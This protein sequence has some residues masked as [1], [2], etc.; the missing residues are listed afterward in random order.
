MLLTS[1][2]DESDGIK[3][4]EGYSSLY[5]ASQ[6]HLQISKNVNLC[7]GLYRRKSVTFEMRVTFLQLHPCKKNTSF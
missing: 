2:N 6:S 7:Y 3:T 1:K 4:F 5:H